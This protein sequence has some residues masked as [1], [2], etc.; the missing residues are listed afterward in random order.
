MADQRPQE[1]GALGNIWGNTEE[2]DAGH[3][4]DRS[5]RAPDGTVAEAEPVLLFGR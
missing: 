1:N 2:A 4:D 5:R 3:F